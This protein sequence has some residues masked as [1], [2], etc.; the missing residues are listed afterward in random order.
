M[1]V[2]YACTK[3]SLRSPQNTLKSMQN[4]KIFL[5]VCPKPLFHNLYYGPRFLYLPWAPPILLVTLRK[6]ISYV[7]K[8][9]CYFVPKQWPSLVPSPH[10]TAIIACEMRTGNEGRLSGSSTMNS[11]I[12]TPWCLTSIAQWLPPTLMRKMVIVS[13]GCDW[14][15]SFIMFFFFWVTVG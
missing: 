8:W 3:R 14:V 4:L 7:T 9:R 11:A 10:S 5:G 13:V 1:Y 2:L 6:L 15:Q 12:Q